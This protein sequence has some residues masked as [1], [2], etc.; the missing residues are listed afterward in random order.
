MQTA[1]VRLPVWLYSQSVGRA[2][3]QMT[4]SRAGDEPLLDEAGEN[5]LDVNMTE[6]E[7]QEGAIEAAIAPNANGEARKRKGTK[8]Q[9]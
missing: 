2:I 6:E 4:G 7:Q 8:Q 3:G 5:A 1:V 9:R